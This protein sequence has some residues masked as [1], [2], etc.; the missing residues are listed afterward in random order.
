MGLKYSSYL[1]CRQLGPTVNPQELGVFLTLPFYK[2]LVT[3]ARILRW[4]KARKE[5]FR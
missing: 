1:A 3:S 2:V 5:L 4:G